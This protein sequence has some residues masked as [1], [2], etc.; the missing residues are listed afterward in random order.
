M[1]GAAVVLGAN[2]AIR[3]CNG[4]LARML[5]RPAL[6]GTD[7]LELV[8]QAQRDL[9]KEMLAAA[10]R[11]PSAA[12][13][14]LMKSDGRE[15]P[16]RAAAAPMSF[17]G[18]PC[19]ALVVTSLDEIDALKRSAAELRDSASARAATEEAL[20]KNAALMRLAA[21][22]AR[23]TYAELDFKLGRLHLAD[24]FA[25][26]MGY[27]PPPLQGRADLARITENL[28]SRVVPEDR[29]RVQDANRKF[30]AGAWDGAVT[31]R[32]IGDDG[33]VRWIEGRWTA[34]ADAKGGL[35]RGIAAS[36]DVT[37]QVEARIELQA[38]K[39]KAEEILSSIADGFYAL[40]ADWRFVYFNARAE[41]LLKKS[42][43]D[44]AGRRF[45]DVFP[46]VADTEVHANY[47]RVMAERRP[48]DFEV[49]SPLLKRFTMFSV[50]PTREGGISVCFRDI[51]KQK[52]AE[53][54]IVGAR[55][56][57]E[58]ADR[59]KSRFLAAA[60]HD[61]R[62]PVQSL[63]LLLSVLERQV[64]DQPKTF[65]TARMMRAAVN[66]LHG[67]LTSVLDISRLDA[68]VVEAVAECV[69]V[70]AV[71]SRLA[72]E[73]APK[74]EDAKLRLRQ[75]VQRLHARTD[76]ALLERALRNLIE[77]ALRYTNEGGILLAVRRKGACVRIDVIDTGI[78]IAADKQADIFEEFHQLN[79]PG[80]DLDQG[81]GLGLAIVAR[82]ANL[83]GAE[84]SVS[85]RVGRGSRFSLSLPLRQGVIPLA[86]PQTEI[87]DPGGRILVVEDNAIV[88]DGLVAL[89]DQCGYETLAAGCGEDALT[90]AA[91]RDWDFDAI[92]LDHRL[93]LG[94]NGLDTATEIQRRAGRRI[95]TMLLTGDTARG[96]FAE[97]E[98]SGY[99][100]LQKPVAADD[101]RRELSR[102]IG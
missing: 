70:G 22:A 24:N 44:V 98:A 86:A 15:T 85:S 46:E 1:P 64:A 83:L 36:L 81:M 84:I 27:A 91:Q 52:E 96:P 93:G 20:R 88:K 5:G 58:R 12:E 100:I 71:V 89:L 99:I 77:N 67:L 80:R 55:A 32:V 75:I 41:D 25:R 49:V 11:A 28:L 30:V 42:R 95:P 65:E 6:A 31:Y 2:H 72:T 101:L 48:L 63:V 66:G 50:Y 43:A 21:D 37:A 62:Q 57:A 23:M 73:Y 35:S 7:L 39:D 47:K 59:S 38:A 76:P 19:V 54:E 78:G 102:L 94:L 29:A 90:I 97:I 8:S 61:L 26:V 68:R 56:E 3:Y 17:D 4:G 87:S 14:A 33:V 18:Q 74:A 51:S 82:L 16:V 10:A 45:F 69:D 92:V 79:N 60:S 13:L 40:D 34:E 53:G 9:M